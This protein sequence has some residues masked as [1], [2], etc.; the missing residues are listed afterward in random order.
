MIFFW[1][2]SGNPAAN[3]HHCPNAAVDVTDEAVENAMDE[4]HLQH[5]QVLLKSIRFEIYIENLC[6]L[7]PM[8]TKFEACMK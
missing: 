3:E 5:T 8:L 7:I 4:H 2:T 6:A 1:Q